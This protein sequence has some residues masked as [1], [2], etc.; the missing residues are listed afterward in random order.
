MKTKSKNLR[1]SVK[2]TA[3]TTRL[4][5][6]SRAHAYHSRPVCTDVIFVGAELASLGCDTLE[7]LL[8][9]RVSVANLHR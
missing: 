2:G 6:H 8:C 4:I 3:E 7:F 9:W 5:I 1:R